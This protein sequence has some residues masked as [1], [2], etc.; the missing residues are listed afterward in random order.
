MQRRVAIWILGVFCILSSFNIESIIGLIL[1]YLHLC[2]FS[3]RA[4]LRAHLLPHNHILHSLLKSRPSI[5]NVSHYLSLDLLSPCQQEIIKGSV[6]NMNNRFNEVFPAFDLLNKEF[7]PR[8]WII[9]IFPSCFSFHPFNKWSKSDL[10]SRSCQLNEVAIVSS[11]NSSCTLIIT[12]T[13]IKNNVTTSIAHIHVHNKP[14]IKTVH[15]AV[16]ITTTEAKLFTI[17]C[18]INQATSIPDIAKI[19][20]ITD[21][22]HAVQRIF[23]S[24]S[25]PFQVYSVFILTELRRFFL[26]EPNN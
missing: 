15:H 23:D 19:I 8:S 21:S 22:L 4:Q 9:D 13:S 1:I 25:H 14:I 20:I 3:G 10:I 5:H 12:D 7:S 26:C 11:L 6:V 17:R 2:K 24:S 16:N 18:G